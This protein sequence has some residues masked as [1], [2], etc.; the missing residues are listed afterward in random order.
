MN[1]QTVTQMST[2][3]LERTIAQIMEDNGADNETIND[4]INNMSTADMQDYLIS[5]GE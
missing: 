1:K 2:K 3:D 4:T 5:I